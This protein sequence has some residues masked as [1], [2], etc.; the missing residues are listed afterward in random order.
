MKYGF[1]FAAIK[2]EGQPL[3]PIDAVMFTGPG[4]TDEWF[5]RQQHAF[6]NNR[7]KCGDSEEQ[8]MKHPFYL[9]A[10]NQIGT[11]N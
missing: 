5:K 7:R 2:A 11:N 8:L 10:E 3:D 9:P 4:A 1:G 6:F